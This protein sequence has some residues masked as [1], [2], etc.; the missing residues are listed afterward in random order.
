MTP[1]SRGIISSGKLGGIAPSIFAANDADFDGVADNLQ[2]VSQTE[3]QIP[4]DKKFSFEYSI[5][6]DTLPANAWV[7]S[8]YGTS[9]EYLIGFRGTSAA[10]VIINAAVTANLIDINFSY[11]F[12]IS[13]QYHVVINSDGAN[14]RLYVNGALEQTVAHSTAAHNISTD[15]FAIGARVNPSV[16]QALNGRIGMFRKYNKTLSL[17][18]VQ[19]N[20]NSGDILCSGSAVS[21]A[22]TDY[23]LANW[24]GTAGQELVDNGS[25]GH[26]FTNPLG[27]A[28]TAG[29]LSVEC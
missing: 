27:I 8:K 1:L 19:T 13:T 23:N 20:Y 5:N 17:S 26:N 15:P 25:G 28:F 29:S 11:V 10:L 18:E 16:I 6:A 24:T 4:A 7:T 9:S 14:A 21:G 2:Q 3:F 12:L 22:V